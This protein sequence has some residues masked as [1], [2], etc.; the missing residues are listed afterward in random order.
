[1][2]PL[3]LVG[4]A[5]AAGACAPGGGYV[6]TSPVGHFCQRQNKTSKKLFLGFITRNTWQRGNKAATKAIFLR[7]VMVVGTRHCSRSRG[8][9]F[10]CPLS[11]FP[12]VAQREPA[13]LFHFSRLAS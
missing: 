8:G 11:F 1:M 13:G 6:S 3:F 12:G 4:V 5:S 9:S 2:W 10:F 7:A